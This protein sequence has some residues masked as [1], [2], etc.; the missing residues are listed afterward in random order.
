MKTIKNYP[1]QA[2]LLLLIFI[3]GILLSFTIKSKATKTDDDAKQYWSVKH[4]SSNWYE[5]MNANAPDFYSVRNAFTNYFSKYPYIK[6]QEVKAYKNFAHH[7]YPN[8]DANGYLIEEKTTVPFIQKQATE[9]N[10]WEQIFLKWNTTQDNG[11]V[12]VLR[13][14][15]INPNNNNSVLAGAVTAGIWQTNDSGNNWKFVSGN[16]PEVEWVNEIIFSRQNPDIVYA[17]TDMGVIKSTNGGNS[18]F[19]TTLKKNFPEKYGRLVWVDV[20][21]NSSEIV[22]ATTEEAD[23]CKLL[24]STDGGNTWEEKYQTAQKIWDMRVKPDNDNVVYIVETSATTGWINFKKSTNSGTSFETITN[25]FPSDYDEKAHRARLATTPANS[26]VVYIAI[27][28]NGGGKNDKI[29]FFKSADAGNSFEKKCCGN[30]NEPLVNA[31]DDTDFLYETAH[32]AQLT[33]NFAFTVSETDENMLA[34]AANKLKVSTDGGNTWHY[35]RSGQVVT[36]KQYD[37]Y[38]SNNAHTGVHGDHHGLSVIGSHIWDANDGG[39][40]Y[41]ADGG[42]TV[43][44]DKSDGLGIQELWGFGQ[45]FKNDIMAVGL[46]HNR[47]CFRDDTVYGGWIAVNGADAMAANVNPID[48]QYMY[49]HPWGHQKVKRSLTEKTGHKFQDLGIQL[50]YITLDNLEFHPNQYYVIYGSDYGDRN[51]TY[52]LTKT[53]DNAES[54]QVIN[55][56]SEEKKN[57]VAVK[58]SFA[59]PNYVYAVVEPNRVIKSTDEGK[60]WTEVGPPASL[61]KNYALWRLAVSDK[62]PDDL[63]VTAKGTQDEVK[64][65]HSKDGGKTWNNFSEGLPSYAIYSMI[66]QRGSNDI[67]YLGTRFGIYYRK[68]G[69]PEWK[70]FG[71]GMPAANTSFMFINYATG[72]L[73][74]GT[75]RGLWQNDLLEQTPPKANITASRVA[76]TK[77]D[78]LVRFA[79]YSVADKNATYK[80]HFEGGIPET[81]TDERPLVSYEKAKKGTHN[82]TLTVTDA[83]GTSTQTLEGFIRVSK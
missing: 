48:D 67:L 66:Y 3:S 44:K 18:W 72:K 52:K 74:V 35:D 63:W 49:T 7:Y 50:G 19:Y 76:V 15:R 2:A 31:M 40:Y 45:S 29:S 71:T 57:A 23:I 55:D 8:I 22:Y 60:T 38:A 9:G 25:G 83:R 68:A 78:A 46:N 73:R 42:H 11:G 17:G 75:S 27:G 69:M 24:K 1:K 81:S 6:T 54:W 77:K 32:L 82:V 12:G 51:K 10:P 79:D 59:N 30:A 5:G 53:T 64:V 47:I 14:I 4:Q 28:F 33:W 20:P 41:S 26:S 56:F 39:A 21:T 13:S 65:I 58:V 70:P 37:K 62:N 80:W 36:G 34:C 16:T 43:V 61:V